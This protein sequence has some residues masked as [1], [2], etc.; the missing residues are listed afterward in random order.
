MLAIDEKTITDIALEQMSATPNSRLRQ[1][2]EIL[3]R[4][5]HAFTRS[6]TLG[7]SSL[8]N[9]L[10]DRRSLELGTKTSL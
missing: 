5:L 3:V 4:H 2:M 8:I 9:T 10:H 7:L 6:D 1:I